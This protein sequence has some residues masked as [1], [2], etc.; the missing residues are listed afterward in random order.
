MYPLLSPYPVLHPAQR[1]VQLDLN[2]LS[3]AERVRA[4][5]PAFAEFKSDMRV[6]EV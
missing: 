6:Y 2:A 3:D 1:S 4:Q 5:W